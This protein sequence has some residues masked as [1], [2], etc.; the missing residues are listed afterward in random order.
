MEKDQK[1][2]FVTY[3]TVQ[4]GCERLGQATIILK[5]RPSHRGH[6]FEVM[7]SNLYP[8]CSIF[9][10]PNCQQ[11]QSKFACGR[12]KNL[13]QLHNR[14]CFMYFCS[15]QQVQNVQTKYSQEKKLQNLRFIEQKTILFLYH[16]AKNIKILHLPFT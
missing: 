1:K 10:S 5:T 2:M 9:M 13:F 7:E 15:V 4:S 14:I 6:T 11:V 8:C 3:E 16:F 12:Y